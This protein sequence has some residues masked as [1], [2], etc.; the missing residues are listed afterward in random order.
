MQGMEKKEDSYIN[1]IEQ[2]IDQE[3][4]FANTPANRTASDTSMTMLRQARSTIVLT[5]P[6]PDN[7]AIG[8]ALSVQHGIGKDR[9]IQPVLFSRTPFPLD[10]IPGND[11]V[12]YYAGESLQQLVLDTGA[13]AIIMVDIGDP[14]RTPLYGEL[15]QTP[16]PIINIDHHIDSCASEPY[17]TSNFT[18]PS[19][20]S[21]TE[22]LFW[23][24]RN[25]KIPITS[26]LATTLLMGIFGDTDYYQDTSLPAR[27]NLLTYYLKNAGADEN[28]ILANS[29]RSTDLQEMKALGYGL[30]KIE[31]RN[32]A[33]FVVLR[34][35]EYH[36]LT[37]QMKRPFEK[38]VIARTLRSVEGID[39]GIV[40]VE[41]EPNKV[42]CSLLG[43]T[44]RINLAKVAQ[45][46][47]GGG[48]PTSAGFRLDG[49][50]DDVKQELTRLLGAY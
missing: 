34:E 26:Q 3:Y 39:V 15:L 30:Q 21:T 10:N 49:N 7:D 12:R 16:L 48:H 24:C 14:H 44:E 47:G 19:F 46:F 35:D 33:A 11:S 6:G 42:S 20:E 2:L 45:H 29:L 43:R 50:I 37:S 5:H 18:D 36:R 40:L 25:E 27:V 8:S 32:N 9:H 23:M 1:L 28:T 17:I 31:V 38:S 13:E 41:S 22:M 4:E